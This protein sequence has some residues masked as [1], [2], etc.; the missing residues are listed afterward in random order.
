MDNLKHKIFLTLSL[1][2][3]TLLVSAQNNTSSPFSRFGYGDLNDNVPGAFRAMGGVGIG[4]RSNKV[5]DP[6]QPASYTAGDSL[7]FMFDIAGSGMWDRYV[8]ASGTHDK[9]NGNLEYVTIQ[10]PLWKQWIAASIGVTP[11]SSVGYNFSLADSV[12]SDYHYTMTYQGTGGFTQVYGGLSFNILNWFA[13]GANIYYMFGTITNA[14]ALA[15]TEGLN[16]TSQYRSTTISDV[17]LRYGAQLF[18]KFEHSEF[19]VG[20][21]FERKSALNGTSLFLES[22]SADTIANDS[23]LSSDLPMVWGV[24]ASY[25]YDGRF[26]LAADYSVY[27]WADARYLGEV[28]VYRNRSKLSVGFQYVHNPQGR[29]YI[30][31]MPWRIGFSLSDAYSKSIPGKDFTVTLGTAFPLHNVGSVINTSIEY[32][33]RG[34]AAMLNENYIRFT[35]NASIAENWFFKRRL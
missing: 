2:I 10:V 27:N 16:A 14:R 17:R 35:I 9:G 8:D 18:H 4:M 7:T 19:T 34:T 15:F 6:A 11:Y 23:T 20:A 32:G 22:V 21:I 25:S 12:N 26:T 1:V 30:D 31:H 5:I 29:N 13:A 33:H 24:G 3:G 28:G